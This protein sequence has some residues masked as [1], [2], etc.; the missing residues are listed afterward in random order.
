MTVRQRLEQ[1]ERTRLSPY[2][3][4]AADTAGGAAPISPDDM[5][6]DFQRDRIGH[7]LQEL[8]AAEI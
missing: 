4:C 6:T 2:A 7:S 3:K 5:R 1:E 8:P